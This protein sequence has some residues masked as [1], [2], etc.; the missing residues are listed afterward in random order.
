MAR[1]LKTALLLLVAAVPARGGD[2]TFDGVGRVVAVSDIHGA[3]AA[4]VR[5]LGAAGVLDGDQ[6]WAAGSD[7]LV[8]VGDILDRGPDSRQSMDLLMRLEGEAEAAGGRVHVLIGNHEAM[9]LT[10]D[11]RYVSREEYAAFAADETAETRERWFRAWVEKRAGGDGSPEE[12]RR[13]FDE[14][15][16]PGFFALKEA[17]GPRGR[18][19]SWLLSRPLLVVVNGTAFV[20]GGLSPVVAELGLEGVNGTL[21][22]DLRRY[23]EAVEILTEAGVLLPTDGYYEHDD[24]VGKPLVPFAVDGKAAAAAA[25][26]PALHDSRI[27]AQ[28]GPLWYR[29]NVACNGLIEKPRL[30]NALDA[31]GARRVV[32]GHTPT[33]GRRVLERFGGRIIEIDTGM[34]SNY[35]KGS[36]HALIIEGDDLS[37]VTERGTREEDPAA[38]PRRV[39]QRAPGIDAD[40]IEALLASGEII[41]QR[42][43]TLGRRIVSV[44]DGERLVD[45]E[46]LESTRRGFYPDIAAY[47]LDLMLGLDMVPVAVRREVDGR[48]GTLRFMPVGTTD[49]SR[50]RETGRGGSA[51]CP[52]PLQWEAMM[53]FDALIYNEGRT[54]ASIQYNQANWQLILTGHGAA[55]GTSKGRPRHLDNIVLRIDETWSNALRSL[56]KEVLIAELGDVLD[57]RRIRALLARRDRLVSGPTG[58]GR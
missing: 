9:N 23:A 5:T 14:R 24:L 22:G 47:R 30:Q 1:F 29:G 16:P 56:D 39:G 58:G 8:I 17:F 13:K 52:L 31:I 12:A 53:V 6:N 20:H 26:L 7:H 2:W 45:A 4:L 36:G 19:G 54:A 41:A 18:Y 46:F 32:I 15:Y 51:M 25:A 44:S 21:V 40:D 28:D 27:H 35:Y 3:H 10:G 11:L 33:F 57:A 50:R 49:E 55:F 48:D 37:V 42:D 38:H 43:D 34:L